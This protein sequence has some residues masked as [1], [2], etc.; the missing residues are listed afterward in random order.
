[1]L[2]RHVCACLVLLQI[3]ALGGCAQLESRDRRFYYRA[4]WNFSLRAQL[5]ELEAEFNG[6]DFGHAHLYETLLVTEAHDVRAVEDTAR[7]ETLRFI[8]SKPMLPPSEEAIA[9][10]YMRLAWRAQNTFDE[11]H[12]LHRATYD[13]YA[14]DYPDKDKAVNLALAHY[15]ESP[16]AITAQSLDHQRLDRLPFAKAFRR[17][18]PLFN[19][20]IWSYHYLQIAAYDHLLSGRNSAEQRR[21]I[22]PLLTTYH[23]YLERPPVEW[24]FMPL[25]AEHSPKFAE[26]HPEV[27]RIFDNLHMLHDTISDILSSD[28]F[29]TR[30][31]KRDAIYKA[32]DTYYLASADQTNPMILRASDRLPDSSAS[33]HGGHE[34]RNRE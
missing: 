17:T 24:T 3:I 23:Q 25:T 27:A 18:F 11:A 19:A 1:M 13:I 12:A 6:V 4:P 32:L 28:L 2:F 31:A 8:A 20:T 34:M 16:Y 26:K 22:V 33:P 21:A 10:T 5:P 15:R 7:R 9:P 14:S 30:D 29:P